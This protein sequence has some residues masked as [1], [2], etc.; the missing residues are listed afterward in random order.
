MQDDILISKLNMVTHFNKL[1][2]T[3]KHAVLNDTLKI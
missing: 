3:V 2:Y 1:H